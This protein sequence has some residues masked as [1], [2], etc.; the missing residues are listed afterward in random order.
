M[1]GQ[2]P[3]LS[4]RVKLT[5]RS[6]LLDF[7][8]SE[9]R[10]ANGYGAD[11]EALKSDLR[12]MV[13]EWLVQVPPSVTITPDEQEQIITET[14][15]EVVGHGPLDAFLSDPTVSEI[16]VNGPHEIFVERA[17]RIERVDATFRDDNHLMSVIERMLSGLNRTVTESDPICDASLPDGSRLNV[18]IPPLVLN[19]P[20]MTIRRKLRDWSIDEYVALEALSKEAAEFLTA[21]VKAGVNMVISGGTSTGK[22]TL[23]SILSEAIPQAERIITIENV[24]ELDL[25]N[26]QHWIRLVAKAPNMEGR[27]E[28]PLRTLVRNALRMRP[29]R[30]ILG[31]ARGGE[32]ADVVQAMHSGHEGVITVL[33][34]NSAEA[35]L[36]RLE[37]LMLMSGLELPSHSC[38][39]Q[40]ASAVDLVIHLARY[41]DGT[42]RI[43]SI[44]Q[45]LGSSSEGFH[46]EELFTFE[47]K[48]FR[49]DATLEGGLRYTGVRPKFLKKFQL[50]NVEVPGWVIV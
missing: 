28:I 7:L 13:K 47:A 29:D 43:S 11:R 32:A 2:P 17:G 34:A 45:V 33:H 27:G 39:I 42:R 6:R 46:L 25:P 20:V 41:A 36:D 18:I 10:T 49:P 5:L 3:G 26:R 16:M 15:T 35:A 40:I 12:R 24:A 9:T 8:S 31:E 38:Q 21:C 23:V 22:T 19:G 4:E 50:N 44:A 1:A 30:I 14:L 37:T 48:G